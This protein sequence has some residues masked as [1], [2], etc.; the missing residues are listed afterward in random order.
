MKTDRNKR[1]INDKWL[2]QELKKK[3]NYTVMNGLLFYRTPQGFHTTSID[4]AMKI[5]KLYSTKILEKY[6]RVVPVES[7][8]YQFFNNAREKFITELV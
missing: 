7:K 8:F 2:L 4:D 6:F 1:R 5:Q 3:P